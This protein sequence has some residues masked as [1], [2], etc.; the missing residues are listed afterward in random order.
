M[1]SP[2]DVIIDI[3]CHR[4]EIVSRGP[5]PAFCRVT[6]KVKMDNDGSRCEASHVTGKHVKN[7]I[8]LYRLLKL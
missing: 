2:L 5:I 6:K 3:P 7:D 8:Q 1:D 4:Q